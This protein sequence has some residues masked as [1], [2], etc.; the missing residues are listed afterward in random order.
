MWPQNEV[1]LTYALYNHSLVPK[2]SRNTNMYHKGI[3]VY[4]LH[5]H[6]R[7][8]NRTKTERQLRPLLAWEQVKPLASFPGFPTIQSCSLTVNIDI[9]RVTKTS[10]PPS[11][12]AYCN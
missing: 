4:F 1:K 12:F 2:L 7:N 8:Q 3:L 10:P 6:E 5:K 9:S 11:V